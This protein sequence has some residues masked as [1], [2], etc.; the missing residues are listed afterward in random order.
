MTLEMHINGKIELSKEVYSWA[1]AEKVIKDWKEKMLPVLTESEKWEVVMKVYSDA[2]QRSSYNL[3][4]KN[5]K[6]K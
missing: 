2:S 3:G 4:N 5:A 6:K 1:Y